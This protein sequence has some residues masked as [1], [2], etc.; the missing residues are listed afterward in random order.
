MPRA[1]LLGTLA[2]VSSAVAVHAADLRSTI[3]GG[4]PPAPAQYKPKIE[5]DWG[6]LYGGVHAGIALGDY[7][8]APVALSAGLFPI[9][10]FSPQIAR[11][12]TALAT[13]L[14]DQKM[15]FGGFVGRNWTEGD[16]V[17]GLELDYTSF[18]G[19]LKGSGGSRINRFEF[20]EETGIDIKRN[21]SVSNTSSFNYKDALLL[22]A[23][24]GQAFDR[25]LPY[26]FVGI[27]AVRVENF[28]SGS[29][30]VS[31]TNA[32]TDAIIRGP[33]TETA[34]KSYDRFVPALAGGLGLDYAVTDNIILRG[35]YTFYGLGDMNGAE[36]YINAFHGGV[37]AKF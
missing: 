34:R 8:S 28:D 16:L 17:L 19:G 5:Y 6:G 23:R 15:Q 10:E 12:S 29:V 2:L 11:Y 30:T 24:F 37:A 21:V 13:K 20:A 9:S 36:G 31:V 4:P 33:S 22:K 26:G 7:R 3:L 27:G 14:S 32:I 35:E 25:F 1:L 18:G